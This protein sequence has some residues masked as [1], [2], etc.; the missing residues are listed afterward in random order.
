MGIRSG[1][2]RTRTVLN[3]QAVG[4]AVLLTLAFLH[5]TRPARHKRFILMANLYVLE[6]IL[7]RVAG[8]LELNNAVFVMLAWNALFA[9]AF[10]YDWAT[11]VWPGLLR[12]CCSATSTRSTRTRSHPS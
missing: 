3:G 2:V 9:S 6:P 1:R 4:F 7:D 12:P 11:F 10:L 8:H 5:R